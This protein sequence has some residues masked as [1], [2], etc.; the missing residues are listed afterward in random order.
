MEI[1]KADSPEALVKARNIIRS[2]GII[3]YPTETFYGLGVDPYNEE[4][5]KRLFALKRRTSDKPVSILVR[6]TKML[7]H[8]VMEAPPAAEGLIKRFWPGPLTILFRST[9]RIPPILT[10]GT[11]KIGVRI[12]GNPQTMK[13]LE[14]V[15][16]PITTTSANPSGS[17][18]PL[19]AKEVANYFD[20]HVELI[21]DG[22]RLSGEL[23]STV[24]DITEGG[25]EIIREGE[26]PT[27]VLLENA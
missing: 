12:A 4:A 23:G 13:L 10:G 1:L 18:P 2:G 22:G 27:T 3:A 19:T 14:V 21:M 15:D 25:L 6:D 8:V 11:G 5:I 20:G 9:S 17:K 7:A 24:V 26:I 16:L